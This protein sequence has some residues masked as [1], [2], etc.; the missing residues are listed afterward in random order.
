M[1]L[2]W[3][4]DGALQEQIDATEADAIELARSCLTEGESFIHCEE[5]GLRA[6]LCFKC[7]SELKKPI[8]NRL[9]QPQLQE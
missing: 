5:G 7:Q 8:I 2:G 4:L 1:A 3:A 9:F 6:H